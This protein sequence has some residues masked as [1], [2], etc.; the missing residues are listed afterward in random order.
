MTTPKQF[1]ALIVVLALT[2]CQS[3]FKVDV[4]IFN[5]SINE[6]RQAQDAMQAAEQYG[7]AFDKVA[8]YAERVGLNDGSVSNRLAQAVSEANA[9]VTASQPGKDFDAELTGANGMMTQIY[10]RVRSSISK[11]IAGW[12]PP[13][14][15]HTVTDKLAKDA[16]VMKEAADA[17]MHRYQGA[18]VPSVM[19]LQARFSESQSQFN[20]AEAEALSVFNQCSSIINNL[21]NLVAGVITPEI[22][23]TLRQRNS[24]FEQLKGDL[25]TLSSNDQK[26]TKAA[27]DAIKQLEP[28]GVLAD[29]VQQAAADAEAATRLVNYDASV[30]LSD[31]NWR[32]LADAPEENWRSFQHLSTEADGS[33]NYIIIQEGMG[34]FRLKKLFNDPTEGYKAGVQIGQKVFQTV[35]SAAIM[36]STGG[37]GATILPSPKPV[38]AGTNATSQSSQPSQDPMTALN[39]TVV[40]N[41]ATLAVLKTNRTIVKTQLG[42]IITDLSTHRAAPALTADYLL[43]VSNKLDALK[44]ILQTN[45]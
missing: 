19:V 26:V 45:N 42:Q 12:P 37:A 2:G 9:A 30:D 23:S 8:Q 20:N 44:G 15:R 34:D 7:K 40:Q 10:P 18:S 1:A 31:P 35:A 43:S 27:N 28:L 17:L 33:A 11:E 39:T 22:L 13:A 6:Y 5:G 24:Q 21:T 32:Y 38:A 36:A 4:A 14:L 41:E 25:S 3:S 29:Q 16:R